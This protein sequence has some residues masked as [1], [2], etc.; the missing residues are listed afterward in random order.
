MNSAALTVEAGLH[1]PNI[2]SITRAFRSKAK[3]LGVRSVLSSA[4]KARRLLRDG[5]A[6]S[7]VA[8]HPT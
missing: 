7:L 4:R 3:S 2:D 5:R 1:N 6:K 8:E